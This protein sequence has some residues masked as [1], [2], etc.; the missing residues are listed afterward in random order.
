MSSFGHGEE[1]VLIPTCAW[2][3]Q[4]LEIAVF[5]RDRARCS[6]RSIAISC[7]NSCDRINASCRGP[8]GVEVKKF[9]R[10]AIGISGAFSLR[11]LRIA[12]SFVRR[13]ARDS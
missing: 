5:R 12:A 4:K 1:L 3:H 10:S 6:Y 13:S 7:F 9:V 11:R 8:S 2:S